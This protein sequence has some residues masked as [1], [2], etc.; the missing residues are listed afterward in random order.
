MERLNAYKKLCLKVLG[1]VD[2]DERLVE[3][4]RMNFFMK[5]RFKVF[6]LFLEIFFSIVRRLVSF[7]WFSITSLTI[8]WRAIA[9]EERL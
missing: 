6:S 7:F 1:F 9:V 4:R 3:D 5:G 8:F 2:R